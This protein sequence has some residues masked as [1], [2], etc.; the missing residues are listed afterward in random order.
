MEKDEQQQPMLGDWMKTQEQ[1]LDEIDE[2]V[3]QFKSL[4]RMGKKIDATKFRIYMI[5]LG[6]KCERSLQEFEAAVL[7]CKRARLLIEEAL[8][9]TTSGTPS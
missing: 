2:N 7:V 5:E 6:D 8:A 1:L 3:R 4:K 9:A